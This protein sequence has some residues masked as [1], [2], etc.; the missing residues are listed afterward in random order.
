MTDTG[1]VTVTV[2]GGHNFIAYLKFEDW[3]HSQYMTHVHMC[4]V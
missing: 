3:S 1:T 4:H 2:G